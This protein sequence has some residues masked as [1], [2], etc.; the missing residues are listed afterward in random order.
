MFN[1]VL[2]IFTE[3]HVS[4]SVECRKIFSVLFLTIFLPST[5]CQE[6]KNCIQTVIKNNQLITTIITL[7]RCDS[8]RHDD[9][10]M[11]TDVL[12]DWGGE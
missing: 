5:I 10:K 9:W 1:V 7:G 6:D 3:Y 12:K 11:F 4:H 2:A 8:D